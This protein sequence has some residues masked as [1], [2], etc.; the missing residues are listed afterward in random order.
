MTFSSYLKQDL[1]VWVLIVFVKFQYKKE[2]EN[3]MVKNKDW[4]FNNIDSRWEK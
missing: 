1:K 3:Y 2:I 4:Q